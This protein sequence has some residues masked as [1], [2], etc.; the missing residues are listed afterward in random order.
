MFVSL[1]SFSQIRV[2]EA[3]KSDTTQYSQSN[4]QDSVFIV[5][6]GDNNK[7]SIILYADFNDIDSLNYYWYK[8]NYHFHPFQK[9][10][11][12]AILKLL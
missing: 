4:N 1:C 9:L 10:P 6:K 12:G 11:Q 5:Y 7:S 3:L 2:K 8:Y